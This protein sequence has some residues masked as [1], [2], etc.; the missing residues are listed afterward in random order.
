[1]DGGGFSCGFAWRAA[2]QAGGLQGAGEDAGFPRTTRYPVDE[3][4][5][6]FVVADDA[7]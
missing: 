4:L 2:H 1:M 6:C 7:L 3:D 5:S